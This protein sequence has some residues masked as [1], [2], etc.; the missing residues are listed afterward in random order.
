MVGRVHGS[1]GRARP[2]PTRHSAR[3]VR[4]K[5][6][7]FLLMS[8]TQKSTTQTARPAQTKKARVIALMSRPNGASIPELC[9]AT[10]WLPKTLRAFVA[11]TVRR[12]LQ[13]RVEASKSPKGAHVYQ[14]TA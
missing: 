13:M 10:R 12:D 3:L 1:D 8:K 5:R 11:V 4:E 9:R 14:I 2:M 7:W 6:K